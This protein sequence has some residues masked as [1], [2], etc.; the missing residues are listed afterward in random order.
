MIPFAMESFDWLAIL[1]HTSRS[2]VVGI[3]ALRA[4][5]DER[6]G[7]SYLLC[8]LLDTYED[9]TQVDLGVRRAGLI[10]CRDLLARMSAGAES[11][12]LE[13]QI[14]G[15]VQINQ[16][17][18]A[19]WHGLDQW[20]RVLLDQGPALWGMIF[21][22]PREDRI[23][24]GRSVGIMADGMLIELESQAQG[25]PRPRS[26]TQVDRYC[27]FVA[28]T[29]GLLLNHL[30]GSAIGG[31]ATQELSEPDAV[32][33]GKLLQL[34]NITKDF[35]QD[36]NEGR[37]FWP[38][39]EAPSEAAAPTAAHLSRSFDELKSLFQKHLKPAEHYLAQIR[40]AGGARS[41]IYFFCAF[42]F[43]MAL[44]TMELAERASD[45]LENSSV[46][47][48]IPRE[49]T[50]RLMAELTRECAELEGAAAT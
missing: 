34:V 32:S 50:E 23:A 11:D 47:L 24:I 26:M 39:I 43:R 18:G 7:L 25:H 29:V 35:H 5:L 15:W 13:R 12:E 37:C 6:V 48:K 21:Q 31:T 44:L 46:V 22:F 42:P 8:R 33:F 14:G 45:W 30:F 27:F 1:K 4:P 49:R 19:T 10:L 40:E 41:D 2:F 38:G 16:L 17:Q 9:S 36:W 28:G 3:Q 20:E